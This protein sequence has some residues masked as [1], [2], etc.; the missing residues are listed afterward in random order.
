MSI[1]ISSMAS[2][3]PL[4]VENAVSKLYF[5]QFITIVISTFLN[6]HF[7]LVQFHLKPMSCSGIN[8][9]YGNIG[10]HEYLEK[11]AKLKKKKRLRSY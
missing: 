1:L 8:K 9:K 5:F 3:S 4:L 11:K 10:L 2:N 7:H 6:K